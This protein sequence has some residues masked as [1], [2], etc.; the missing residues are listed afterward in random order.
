MTSWYNVAIRELAALPNFQFDARWI[1]GQLRETLPL[2]QIEKALSFL[3]KNGFL[4][5]TAPF[6][7]K[8]PIECMGGVFTLSL[9]TFHRQ[10]LNQ[11][12]E[13]IESV[14]RDE[15]LIDDERARRAEA[16]EP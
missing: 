11:I 12:S 13:S 14:P 1:Q 4:S 7:S 2:E 8:K 3:E 5:R 9:G 15:R 16:V 10:M 6:I